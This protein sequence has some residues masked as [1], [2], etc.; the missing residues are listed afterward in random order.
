[1]TEVKGSKVTLKGGEETKTRAKNH[2]KV[3]EKRP[4]ELETGIQIKKK[5]GPELDLEVSWYRIQAMGDQAD[6]PGP[7][8]EEEDLPALP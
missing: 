1:M 4:K 2:V 5:R 8:E 6:A 3:V 7:P